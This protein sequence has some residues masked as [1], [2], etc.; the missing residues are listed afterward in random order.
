MII[1]DKNCRL[2]FSANFLLLNPR[3]KTNI[4]A[5]KFEEPYR[6]LNR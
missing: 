4:D 6:E 3:I 5:T 1:G 2:F